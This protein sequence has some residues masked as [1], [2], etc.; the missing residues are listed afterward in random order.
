MALNKI[1]SPDPILLGNNGI[2][3]D[4]MAQIYAGADILTSTTLGEGWGL[5]TTEAMACKTPVV[6]PNNSAL[7][8]IIGANNERGYLVKSGGTPNHMQLF[9]NDLEIFR[10]LTDIEDLIATWKHVY[11][12]REEAKLK[13]EEA[14]KWV[15][16][17]SWDIIAKQWDELFKTAYASRQS[18]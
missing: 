10:P 9:R 11:D 15:Q 17:I 13:A 16:N 12:N 2:P 4:K 18:I 1:I 7:T 3:V 8:E 5:S 14:F 6:M